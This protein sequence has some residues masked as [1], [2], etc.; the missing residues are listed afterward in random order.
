MR[1]GISCPVP[2]ISSSYIRHSQPSKHSQPR[3][4]KNS[5]KNAQSDYNITPFM[6]RRHGRRTDI[7]RQAAKEDRRPGCGDRDTGRGCEQSGKRPEN[8]N[9][10][11]KKHIRQQKYAD[12]TE[13][14]KHAGNRKGQHRNHSVQ[15]YRSDRER[16][17]TNDNV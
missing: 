17:T 7:H 9:R 13:N 1:D 4:H 12:G 15:E 10:T 2:L 3:P 16:G 8:G 5:A 11:V 6:L 14:G